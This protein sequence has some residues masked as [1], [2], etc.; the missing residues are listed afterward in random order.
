M[1]PS[2]ILKELITASLEWEQA[3]LKRFRLLDSKSARQS[4]I[5]A[6][7]TELVKAIHRLRLASRA[8]R[9]LIAAGPK[10]VPKSI[11]W[12]AVIKVAAKA[13]GNVASHLDEKPEPIEATV[14][15][16]KPLL[17]K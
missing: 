4:E 5:D 13:L 2:N 12:G 17:T 16:S 10:K 14:I 1:N 9:K 8:M 7:N 11:N 3:D 6:A 15:S